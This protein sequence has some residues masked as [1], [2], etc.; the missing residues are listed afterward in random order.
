M[1]LGSDANKKWNNNNTQTESLK[2]KLLEAAHSQAPLKPRIEE[3]QKKLQTQISKLD[4]MS[5]K[6]Q[7]KD[8]V[9]FNRIVKAMHNHDSHYARLLSGELSQIRK[10]SKMIGSAKL[11]FEQIQLRLNTLT[12][13]GDIVV[14]LSPAMS[15]IK[16]IQG[17]LSSM[18][19]QA[20]QSFG[21]I[22][23]LVGSIMSGSSQMPSAAAGIESGQI[24]LD[25]EAMSIIEE[26]SSMVEENTKDKFPDLPLSNNKVESTNKGKI[27]SS[28]LY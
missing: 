3:A 4:G 23:D 21:Q 15:A 20:D 5:S 14:T 26:A 2:D 6:L 18:M 11:A 9:I 16:G 13:F 10:I 25:E 22:S 28:S 19:P 1:I 17:G 12:E 7:E 8:K 24:S 27:A